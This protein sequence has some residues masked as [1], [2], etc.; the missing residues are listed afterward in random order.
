MKLRQFNQAS[1]TD[2]KA[3]IAHCVALDEWVN[4][5]V[6]H[7]PYLF[8]DALYH[9]GDSLS[10]QWDGV[11]LTRALSAHPRIGERAQ[12]GSKE[13]RLSEGEQAGVN[14]NDA[15]L[16]EALD[17]GNMAYEQRF[18]RVFLIR[19][20]GRSGE[21]ILAELSR[22]LTNDPIKEQQEALEQLRDITLLRLK[23]T[24]E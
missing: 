4:E 9:Q 21:E 12:G 22:R 19:A 6:A 7:R 3:L 20:K 8:V 16:K 2:A 18:G 15:R 1:V 10:K 24:F 14:A 5:M 17:T 23:E 13:V 11:A